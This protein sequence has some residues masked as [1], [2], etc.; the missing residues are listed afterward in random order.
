MQEVK[1]RATSAQGFKLTIAAILPILLIAFYS[2]LPHQFVASWFGRRADAFEAVW[3]QRWSFF[4]SAADS[5][6]VTAYHVGASGRL[7]AIVTNQMSAKNEWG[8]GSLSTI[9]FYELTSLTGTVP[10]SAWKPCV[11]TQLASCIEASPT[12]HL[13]NAFNPA[14]LCGRLIIFRFSASAV[15][16]EH[17][18]IASYRG[19]GA[20]VDV[21]CRA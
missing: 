3:P 9:Q 21:E 16:S 6:F 14:V 12:V 4:A 2:Q 5:G 15:K 17:T 8:L 11:D 1:S 7:E 10:A 20:S 19:Y 13:T 18:A